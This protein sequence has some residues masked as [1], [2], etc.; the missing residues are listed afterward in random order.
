MKREKDKL[1]EWQGPTKSEN[2]GQRVGKERR[3]D[4]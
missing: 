4:N 2:E 3:L 1:T